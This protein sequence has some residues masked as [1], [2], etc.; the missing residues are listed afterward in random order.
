MCHV[1]FDFMLGMEPYDLVAACWI[2]VLQDL[3]LNPI[4]NSRSLQNSYSPWPSLHR[5]I[6]CAAAR[7]DTSLGSQTQR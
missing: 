2:Y 5:Y 4:A 7:T 6:A 3:G 1:M